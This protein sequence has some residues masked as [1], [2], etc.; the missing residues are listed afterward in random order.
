MT[1]SQLESKI[2]KFRLCYRDSWQTKQ[3]FTLYIFVQEGISAD[4][5]FM[6]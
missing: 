3:L 2:W 4:D 5:S 6:E 1:V